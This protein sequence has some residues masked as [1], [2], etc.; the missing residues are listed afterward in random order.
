MYTAVNYEKPEFSTDL[1]SH[2]RQAC[3]TDLVQKEREIN[4]LFALLFITASGQG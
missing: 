3:K 2:S 4:G 1:K